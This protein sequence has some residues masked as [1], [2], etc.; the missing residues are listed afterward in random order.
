MEN[1][2]DIRLLTSN[3][4][5]WKMMPSI[6]FL[7]KVLFHMKP[8]AQTIKFKGRIKVSSDMHVLKNNPPGT[9]SAEDTGGFAP[10]KEGLTRNA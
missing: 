5:S 8:Y 4:G 2:N 7:E 1:R 6:F 10:P 3:T 9:H